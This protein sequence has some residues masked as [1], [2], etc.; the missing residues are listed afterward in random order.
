[1]STKKIKKISGDDLD[2]SIYRE[3]V[4][5]ISEVFWV[6]SADGQSTLF[7]SKA[8]EKIWGRPVEDLYKKDFTWTQSIH[9]DDR[10]KVKAVYLAANKA[11]IFMIINTALFVLMGLSAGF[12]IVVFP[13]G[14]LMVQLYALPEWRWI[15]PSLKW[16]KKKPCVNARLLSRR[17]SR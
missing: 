16:L 4:T 14:M 12:M 6:G 2:S 13:S 7:A 15:S 9:Q 10:E 11:G 3:L 17:T 5:H 8:Y 1:M